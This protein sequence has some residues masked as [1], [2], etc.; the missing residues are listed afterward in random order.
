MQCHSPYLAALLAI[1]PAA[2]LSAGYPGLQAPNPGPTNAATLPLTASDTFSPP[3]STAA[4]ASGASAAVISQWVSQ[5]SPGDIIPLTGGQLVGATFSIFGQT[6]P[7][8]ALMLGPDALTETALATQLTLNHCLPQNSAYLIWAS[9]S[10]GVSA[11]IC[12]NCTE[13]WWGQ[14]T[15]YPGDTVALFGRNLYYGGVTP[16]VYVLNTDG[17]L[18]GKAVLVDYNNYRIRYVM[19]NATLKSQVQVWVHNGHGG[20]YGWAGP[21][22]VTVAATVNNEAQF[23]TGAT[24]NVKNFGAVGDGVTDDGP[25]ITMALTTAAASYSSTGLPATVYLPGSPTAAVYLTNEGFN[26]LAGVRW[27]GD[28]PALTTLELGPGFVNSV[29]PE[30]LFFESTGQKGH[31]DNIEFESMTLNMNGNLQTPGVSTIGYNLFFEVGVNFLKFKNLVIDSGEPLSGTALTQYVQTSTIYMEGEASH[32]WV[33]DCTVTG[34]EM[35]F[36]DE[37][38]VFVD[39]C[40]FYGQYDCGGFLGSNGGY[41]FSA[42]N[43]VAQD[44]A[45]FPGLTT[46]ADSTVTPNPYYFEGRFFA[47][48]G[49]GTH[50]EYFSGNTTLQCAPRVAPGVNENAGEQLL[51]ESGNTYY[52]G[53]LSSAGPDSIQV[54][55]ASTGYGPDAAGRTY[56][57]VVVISGDGLGQY[58]RV[59]ADNGSGLLTVSPAWAIPPDSTSLVQVQ[60]LNDHIA[61]FAN[62]LQGKADYATAGTS[63]TGVDPY[64]NG[65]SFVADQNDISQMVTGI[66]M[67]ASTGTNAGFSPGYFNLFVNNRIY[68]CTNGVLV[69]FDN[70]TSANVPGI[71]LLATDVRRNTF[72]NSPS[73]PMAYG[74]PQVDVDTTDATDRIVS[75]VLDQNSGAYVNVSQ[76]ATQPATGDI[77]Y[78]DAAPNNFLCTGTTGSCG[79]APAPGPC[80]TPP[81]TP[82]GPPADPSAGG[83]L[84]IQNAVP[85][86]DPNPATL[87][88][89]M[90]GPADS[91]DATLYT[92]AFVRVGEVRAAPI[93]PGW[94]SV[95]L[96]Q[97]LA[98][99]PI[100]EYFVRLI[101]WRGPV[102]SPA[103]MTRL[104]VMR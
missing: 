41:G 94:N 19:P 60:Q 47:A 63:S 70:W 52:T 100:G 42:T 87:G 85:I 55:L 46:T 86:P 13:L 53:P 89:S 77:A 11:P 83:H 49:P 7:T 65:F 67:G 29:Q 20:A 33:Q 64:L 22:T 97:A 76:S 17:S 62:T 31:G 18:V 75:T 80:A 3:T 4:P 66:G 8:N 48:A 78:T 102:A 32:A 21:V 28:G 12:V 79:S 93:V 25:A 103:Y 43:C 14:D 26:N 30:A 2:L 71:S 51:W 58:R 92:R 88:V 82:A 95:P 44:Y 56:Y 9:T 6:S 36:G 54:P 10:A 81:T 74:L 68:N 84:T 90:A 34:S 1:L 15:A 99:L 69:K 23:W 24:F 45:R 16:T 5:G 72:P 61:I 57:Y 35:E 98:G 27:L 37:N 38:Q 40:N 73:T 104:Y 50:D 59:T 39:G 96:H 91:L 101:A